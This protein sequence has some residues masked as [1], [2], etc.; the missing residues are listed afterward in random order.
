MGTE[1]QPA[2]LFTF[3]CSKHISVSQTNIHIFRVR[4]RPFSRLF[5]LNCLI[6]A[7]Y[8]YIQSFSLLVM[9]RPIFTTTPTSSSH[10]LTTISSN[11]FL[12][13]QLLLFD[14]DR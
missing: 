12:V 9:N 6:T 11:C 2:N 1:K 8:V 14:D 13:K 4:A 5:C 3:S 10:S 7:I